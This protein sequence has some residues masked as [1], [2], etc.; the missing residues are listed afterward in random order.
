M[1]GGNDS[2]EEG[3][4][5]GK[6]SPRKVGADGEGQPKTK[7]VKLNLSGLHT[8]LNELNGNVKMQA[9]DMLSFREERK[10]EMASKAAESE[11][12]RK[13][14]AAM[15]DEIRSGVAKLQKE[16]DEFKREFG[17]KSTEGDA[18]DA[19]SGSKENIRG[20][21]S[22]ATA[23][24]K[25]GLVD[26]SALFN[27]VV[28]GL[29]EFSKHLDSVPT[30][31]LSGLLVSLNFQIPNQPYS[32]GADMMTGSSIKT[33]QDTVT[34]YAVMSLLQYVLAKG[35]PEEFPFLDVMNSSIDWNA[36][37]KHTAA[38][39]GFTS[40]YKAHCLDNKKAGIAVFVPVKVMLLSV[41][42]VTNPLTLD[43][44]GDCD[45]Q[46]P[47]NADDVVTGPI[48]D[49]E[50]DVNDTEEGCLLPPKVVD[51]LLKDS[52][53]R[54]DGNLLTVTA[55][56]LVRRR[57]ADPGFP[58]VRST[59]LFTSIFPRFVWSNLSCLTLCVF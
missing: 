57:Q 4:D 7:K 44:S 41:E 34:R 48:S 36:M 5:S 2:Q 51:D 6:D 56:C 23:L 14:T 22:F 11:L 47:S 1:D 28:L 15:F 16:Q 35:V 37:N 25:G 43:L 18:G 46:P 20:A 31:V 12:S 42:G 45:V 13:A 59:L 38:S 17:K 58:Q 19:T 10:I 52:Y 40:L 8:I 49:S 29:R 53:R 27:S 50:E 21:V 3:G 26:A 39:G 55:K 24:K 54:K 9:D 30:K 32:K 33:I